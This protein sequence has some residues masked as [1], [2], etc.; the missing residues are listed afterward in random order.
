MSP[1]SV[2]LACHKLSEND[3]TGSEMFVFANNNK[4]SEQ[5]ETRNVHLKSRRGQMMNKTDIFQ[6]KPNE[7]RYTNND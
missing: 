1:T 2:C 4:D 6:I 5:V 3:V 7:N